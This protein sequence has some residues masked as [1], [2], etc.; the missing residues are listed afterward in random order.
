MKD[1][2]IMHMNDLQTHILCVC[3]CI[4]EKCKKNVWNDINNNNNANDDN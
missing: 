1:A 3:V 2:F 4:I